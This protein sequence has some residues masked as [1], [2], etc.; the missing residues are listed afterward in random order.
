MGREEGRG[1]GEPSF[2]IARME[3]DE[4]KTRAYNGQEDE[5]KGEFG[6]CTQPEMGEQ[7]VRQ[8]WI[9]ELGVRQR[10]LDAANTRVGA[11]DA[12]GLQAEHTY[13]DARTYARTHER[14]HA[15]REAVGQTERVR[16]HRRTI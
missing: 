10:K 14:T 13:M 1:G 11:V 15:R 12:V 2:V 7:Q 8:K 6:M 3:S 5:S 16:A 4:N 9:M